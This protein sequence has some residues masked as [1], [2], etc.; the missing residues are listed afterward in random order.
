MQRTGSAE[1]MR[2]VSVADKRRHSGTYY[3][4]DSAEDKTDSMCGSPTKSEHPYSIVRIMLAL[5]IVLLRS[6]SV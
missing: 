6:L 1:V 3:E 4:L 2:S 5:S